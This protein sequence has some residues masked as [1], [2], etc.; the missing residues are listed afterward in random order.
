MVYGNPRILKVEVRE[1]H[2][3]GH[4]GLCEDPRSQ[5]RRAASGARNIAQWSSA[6]RA[7]LAS[8]FD[9]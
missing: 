7:F 8:Q 5:K 2:V 6:C 9:P 1:L 4:S 3:Q